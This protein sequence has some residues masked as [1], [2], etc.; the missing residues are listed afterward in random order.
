MKPHRG[1]KTKL[2][3][4]TNTYATLVGLKT[5][6]TAIE[7]KPMTQPEIIE[8]T[9]LQNSTVSRWLARL[10]IKPALVYIES[11]RRTGSRGQWAKVWSAG[12][13]KEDAVK[14]EPLTSSQYNK[15]WRNKQIAKPIITNPKPGVIRHVAK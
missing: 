12:F 1:E 15:R 11:Y 14:P 8:L 7:K 10:H 9:G 5:L 2:G 6:L 13:N 3:R 4:K